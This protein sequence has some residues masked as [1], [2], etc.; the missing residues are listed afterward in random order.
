MVAARIMLDGGIGVPRT[1]PAADEAALR[2]LRHQAVALGVDWPAGAAYGDVL[3][4]L[5]RSGPR[6]AAF[7]AAATSLFRGA[8]WTPF[9]GASPEQPDHG[10]VGTPYAHVTAPLRRL[11]EAAVLEHHVS[12]VFVVVALDRDTVQ[13]HDP[14]VVADCDGA[15]LREGEPVRVRLVGLT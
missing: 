13:L 10:A 6:V 15:H 14:A 12:E 1:I 3:A 8:A 7:L 5:D 11:V 9:V 4:G 2:C